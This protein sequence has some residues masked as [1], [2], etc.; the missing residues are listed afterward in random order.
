MLQQVQPTLLL[1]T[2]LLL[3]LQLLMLEAASTAR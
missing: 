2:Q 1:L 3:R